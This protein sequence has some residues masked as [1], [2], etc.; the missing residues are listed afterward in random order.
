MFD[1][2]CSTST[3]L[4]MACRKLRDKHKK[5]RS[6]CRE[7]SEGRMR[8]SGYSYH[9]VRPPNILHR[10]KKHASGSYSV[11]IIVVFR[12]PQFDLCL[13]ITALEQ[14]RR[15]LDPLIPA[16]HLALAYEYV[17][18]WVTSRTS[19][20]GRVGFQHPRTNTEL[21]VHRCKWWFLASLQIQE[22]CP[23]VSIHVSILDSWCWGPTEKTQGRHCWK[24]LLSDFFLPFDGCYYCRQQSTFLFSRFMQEYGERLRPMVR[25][26]VYYMYEALHGPPK[27]ILVEGANAALLDIDFGRV[28]GT[29][30]LALDLI[31][32]I[33][34]VFL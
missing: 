13:T 14:P 28:I 16:K 9:W 7:G 20:P 25:D 17:T 22:P 26:G 21:F 6:K 1:F 30:W 31:R 5:E 24:W 23:A 10:D 34:E 18:F 2:Q 8:L 12:S 15:A 3:R 29:W 19:L 32:W 11:W 33:C 4:S 27:K